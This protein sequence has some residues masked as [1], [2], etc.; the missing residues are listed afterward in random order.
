MLSCGVVLVFYLFVD[1]LW[2][3][4]SAVDG[5]GDGNRILA[6]AKTRDEFVRGKKAVTTIFNLLLTF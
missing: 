2:E 5:K 1:F 4:V 3:L 6:I